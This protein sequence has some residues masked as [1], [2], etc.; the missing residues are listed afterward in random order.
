MKEV[1]VEKVKKAELQAGEG[2]G[3]DY[4]ALRLELEN[5]GVLKCPYQV[6]V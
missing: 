2:G 3:V 1:E 4:S 6:R 5:N